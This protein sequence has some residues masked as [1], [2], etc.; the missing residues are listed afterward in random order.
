[1]DRIAGPHCNNYVKP[2]QLDTL[3][4]EVVLRAVQKFKAIANFG[5]ERK[6]EEA[7]QKFRQHIDENFQVYASL[8]E[9]RNP[10]AGLETYI[11]PMTIAIISYI[12]RVVADFSCSGWSSVC[13]KSSDM[14][15]HIFA[16]VACF[17]LIL[18][19]TK[20][21][22]LKEI[23]SKVK[24]ALELFFHDHGKVKKD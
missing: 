2:E 12:L 13:R 7:R 5:N 24:S 10:L 22:Q 15:S 21:Q 6:I 16:V 3:H 23:F 20:A 19:M 11:I 14:L 17:M 8:N 9:S 1:M 18:A 4:N